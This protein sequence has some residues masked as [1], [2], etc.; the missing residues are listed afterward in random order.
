MS[1]T[2][3]S[4]A[5]PPT[6]AHNRSIGG[7]R[8]ATPFQGMRF[9]AID[10]DEIGLRLNI[11]CVAVLAVC[12]CLCDMLGNTIALGEVKEHYSIHDKL[13]GGNL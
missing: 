13:N 12:E 8:G 1:I 4:P 6:R 11:A 2:P 3:S 9:G 5:T 7:G 10:P